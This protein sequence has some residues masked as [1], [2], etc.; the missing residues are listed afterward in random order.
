MP[1]ITMSYQRQTPSSSL[2][3]VRDWFRRVM[4][5]ELTY[6]PPNSQVS[7]T[8]WNIMTGNGNLFKVG[9]N[10]YDRVVLIFGEEKVHWVY[11][12]NMPLHVR[13]EGS[14]TLCISFCSCCLQNQYKRIIKTIIKYMEDRFSP[15]ILSGTPRS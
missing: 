12:R 2:L 8:E 11:Y 9:G 4:N 13:L 7:F 3:T 5:R 15:Q 6:H 14:D 1:R 10:F